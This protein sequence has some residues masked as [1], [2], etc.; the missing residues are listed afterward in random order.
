[1]ISALVLAGNAEAHIAACLESLAWVDEIVVVDDESS[2]GTRAI[3]SAH[4][5]TVL[6]RS[7]DR[8]DAQRNFGLEQC[9]GEWVLVVDADERVT[10]ELQAEIERVVLEPGAHAGFRMPR[11]NH[12]MGTRVRF[13]GWYPDYVVR[14][15]RS[16][17]ARYQGAVH[18]RPVLTGSLG[19][20]RGPL[21]HFTYETLEQFA[22]KADRYSTMAAAERWSAG[23]RAHWWDLVLRPAFELVKRY[24]L[25]LG[26]LDGMSGIVVSAMSAYYTFLKY[27]KL[28]YLGKSKAGSSG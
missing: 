1:M 10:S 27:A 13:C 18:E 16:I 6:E 21:L 22:A 23:R 9:H 2:D 24:V 15:F 7:L 12:V 14:L 26:F 19:T 20:L 4:G 11:R 8:F 28:H 3:A 5:A 25:R 17:G